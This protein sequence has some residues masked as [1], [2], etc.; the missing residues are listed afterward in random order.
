LEKIPAHVK[1]GIQFIPVKRAEEV[2]DAAFA[3]K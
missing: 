3:K 1:A 2:I